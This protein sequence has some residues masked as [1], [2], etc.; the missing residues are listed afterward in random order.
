MSDVLAFLPNASE[1]YYFVS[2]NAE[3]LV[4]GSIV[5]GAQC[6]VCGES[7]FEIERNSLMPKFGAC[8]C[9]GCNQRYRITTYNENDVV[10]PA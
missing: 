1:P 3:E 2:E 5:N 7:V 10:F 4:Y 9:C 6:E 8:R